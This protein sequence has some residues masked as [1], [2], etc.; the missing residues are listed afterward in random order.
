MIPIFQSSTFS[1]KSWLPS[2]S[3]RAPSETAFEAGGSNVK[4]DAESTGSIHRREVRRRSILL[5]KCPDPSDGGQAGEYKRQHR[6][7]KE[8]PHI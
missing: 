7:L 2:I 3:C 4:N 6:L 1:I 8:Q 5:H